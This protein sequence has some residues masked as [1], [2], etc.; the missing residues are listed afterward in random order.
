MTRIK[1]PS[2]PTSVL[3]GALRGSVL[4]MRVPVL[5]RVPRAAARRSSHVIL[6]ADSGPTVVLAVGPRR[7][8]RPAGDAT[9]AVL[10]GR[11]PEQSHGAVRSRRRYAARV[12]F[13]C[14]AAEL[15]AGPWPPRRAE[16]DARCRK[17]APRRARRTTGLV[18]G[19]ERGVWA[20]GLA[21][22][23]V[24]VV[25]GGVGS[26]YL[27]GACLGLPFNLCCPGPACG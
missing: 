7:A 13:P 24:G 18:G 8:R 15:R 22:T 3:N 17:A 25:A 9:A 5:I 1:G 19:A 27:A 14:S 10:P 4:A 6:A 20:P 12:R 11:I 23:A 16:A 21:I 2:P 26:C